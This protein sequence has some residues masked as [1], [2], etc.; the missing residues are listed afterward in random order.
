MPYQSWN[1]MTEKEINAVFS[2]PHSEAKITQEMRQEQYDNYLTQDDHGMVIQGIVNDQEG[3]QFFI[4][5]NSWGERGNDH[6]PGY[7]YASDSYVRLKTISVMMHKD[8]LPKSL[9]RKLNIL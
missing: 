7:L 2:G 8:S 5:K 1:D 4:V 3:N 9:R 6:R